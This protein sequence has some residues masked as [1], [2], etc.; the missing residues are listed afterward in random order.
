MIQTESGLQDGATAQSQQQPN[1]GITLPDGTVITLEEA[2]QGYMRNRD[3]TQKTQDLAN[4][5]RIAQ[6]GLDLLQALD[7]D[8]KATVE[9]IANTYK[10]QQPVAATAPAATNEWGEPIEAPADTPEVAALKAEIQQLRGTVGTVAQQQQRSALMNELADVQSRYGD[11]DHEVVLRHMQANDIPTV[12]MAYRDLNWVEL[13]ES[14]A[15]Q[16]AIEAEQQQV[17]EEKRMMQGVVAAGAGIPGGNVD[18]G[19]K[20]YSPA[21]QGSWRDTLAEA[22]RD[23]MSENGFGYWRSV[24]ERLTFGGPVPTLLRS[25]SGLSV[26]R[27]PMLT[28][29]TF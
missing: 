24:A 2:A 13:Q 7:Q 29:Q 14:A 23:S 6:R 19:P 4:Q 28:G 25:T 17:L 18:S 27:T 12:E 15:T 10:I 20:D 1:D 8:P 9:L 3:Y 21:T 22:L 5:R 16:R 11:F 26:T